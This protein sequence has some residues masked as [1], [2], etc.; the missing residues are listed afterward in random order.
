MNLS[1]NISL[2]IP[3]EHNNGVL[4]Y[5]N[6][7]I[8]PY[9][10]FFQREKKKWSSP[11]QQSLFKLCACYHP[12]FLSC[13]PQTLSSYV[14]LI[15][16]HKTQPF[17]SHSF[18]ATGNCTIIYLIFPTINFRNSIMPIEKHYIFGICKTQL[19]TF[20]LTST[21]TYYLSFNHLSIP[22]NLSTKVSTV[23]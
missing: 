14:L 3:L 9:L 23:L 1:G 11:I 22:P 16:F 7:L 8:L 2:L 20:N 5:N 12:L 21:F 4:E 18:I 10:V 13:L 6:V 17:L 19:P 15:I